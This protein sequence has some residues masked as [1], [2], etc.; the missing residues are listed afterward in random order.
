MPRLSLGLGPQNI[1]KVGGGAPSSIPLSTENISVYF[2]TRPESSLFARS[3]GNP[4]SWYGYQGWVGDYVYF[5]ADNSL[6]YSDGKWIIFFQSAMP[7]GE[8]QISYIT[9]KASV[10]APS[11]SVPI[12]GWSI[13]F[14]YTFDQP[15]G[16]SLPTISASP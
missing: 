12:T 14:S 15:D 13:E 4:P 8:E 6:T 16:A 1:R 10:T 5:I 9:Y 2:S 11:T 7:S 3:A